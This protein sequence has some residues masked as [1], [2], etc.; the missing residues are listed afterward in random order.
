MLGG[1]DPS[2]YPLQKK[3]HTL[4]FL[5]G[6]GHLRTR[7]N[8]IASVMRVRNAL[9]IATHN[10]FQENGF[11]YVNSPIISAADCEGAGEAFQVRPR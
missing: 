2:T 9:S 1:C 8:T 5:R 7:T 3:R 4:E 11:F 6:I 10:F